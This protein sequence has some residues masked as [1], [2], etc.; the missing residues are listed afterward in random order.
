[1]VMEPF[2]SPNKISLDEDFESHIPHQQ[3]EQ[4]NSGLAENDFVD[5]I[6]PKVHMCFDSLAAVKQFYRNYGIK[7]GFGIRTRTSA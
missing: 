1:M 5:D 7:S 2:D 6:P 4:V 3:Y